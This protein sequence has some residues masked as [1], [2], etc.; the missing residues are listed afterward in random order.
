MALS[1]PPAKDRQLMPP[2]AR[3]LFEKR[4]LDL[5]K[6]FIDLTLE[7]LRQ[8]PANNSVSRVMARRAIIGRGCHP[9]EEKDENF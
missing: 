6:L 8:T 5:Q 1:N 4:F 9:L 7:E 2:A 3:N